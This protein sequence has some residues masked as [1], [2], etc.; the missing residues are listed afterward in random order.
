[1][2]LGGYFILILKQVNLNN[3]T[4]KSIWEIK[5]ITLSKL[6]KMDINIVGGDEL[7]WV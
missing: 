6:L 3:K 2:A 1:L 7:R 4:D 5:D